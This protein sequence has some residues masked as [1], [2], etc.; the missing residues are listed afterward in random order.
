MMTT[1]RVSS[2]SVE[3]LGEVCMISSPTL[4]THVDRSW[5]V[6]L[7]HGSAIARNRKLGY[8][9]QRSSFRAYFGVMIA[10]RLPEPE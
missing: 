2:Q 10:P 1:K 4:H 6:L 9:Q 3:I 5:R 7:F 8:K